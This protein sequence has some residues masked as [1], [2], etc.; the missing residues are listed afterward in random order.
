MG[1]ASQ[2]QHKPSARAKKNIK[3]LKLYTYE[4][5]HQRTSKIEIIT[6]E[7]KYSLWY[8]HKKDKVSH[9]IYT[10]LSCSFLTSAVIMGVQRGEMSKL[11]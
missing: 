4:A 7:M 3:F 1:Y 2:A 9:S 8:Q 10:G 6:G 11:S 5:L